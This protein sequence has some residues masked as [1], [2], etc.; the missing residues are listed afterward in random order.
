MLWK[1]TPKPMNN[2]SKTFASLRTEQ[3]RKKI[4]I[5]VIGKEFEQ[6]FVSLPESN[7]FFRCFH[8]DFPL[9]LWK[10]IK[11]EILKKTN[12]R[13][14]DNATEKKSCFV[15]Q[16]YGAQQYPDFLVFEDSKIWAIETKFNQKEGVPPILEQRIAKTKQHLYLRLRRQKA[17]HLFRWQR[18]RPIFYGGANAPST[19]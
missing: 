16:P 12:G 13:A 11:V 14:M 15:I 6:R 9:Q 7:R 17:N 18:R 4:T 1:N 5:A 8:N 3:T 2:L 19:R 10:S